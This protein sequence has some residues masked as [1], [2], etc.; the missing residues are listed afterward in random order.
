MEKYW[1]PNSGTLE[2]FWQHEF[3]KHA[4]CIN[5]LAPSCYGEAYKQGDEVVD[6]FAKAT[7]VFK[8][9][10]GMYLLVFGAVCGEDFGWGGCGCER[11]RLW[12]EFAFG[13]GF[14]GSENMKKN[15]RLM[16]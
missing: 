13:R 4:T 9:C 2:H 16:K 5:T 12:H 1:L 10:D 6:F 3:N 7:E 14:A 15:Q 8:V 11:R